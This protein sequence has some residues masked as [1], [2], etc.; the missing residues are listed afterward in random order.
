MF[1]NTIIIINIENWLNDQ[2]Q[3]KSP[4]DLLFKEVPLCIAMT[5]FGSTV[6]DLDNEIE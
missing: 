3:N 4:N 2:L 1:L 5:L 6:C